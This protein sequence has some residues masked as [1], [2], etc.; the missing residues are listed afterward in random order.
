MCRKVLSMKE[1]LQV[2]ELIA[3]LEDVATPEEAMEKMEILQAHGVSN[4][5]AH[6]LAQICID[7]YHEALRHDGMGDVLVEAISAYL[8]RLRSLPERPTDRDIN[9]WIEDLLNNFH[10][11]EGN[12][13]LTNYMEQLHKLAEVIVNLASH[14]EMGVNHEFFEPLTIVGSELYNYVVTYAEEIYNLEVKK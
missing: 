8:D 6:V 5:E 7:I 3:L 13:E 1:T 4:N 12:A 14:D 11:F 9:M 10:E 2:D